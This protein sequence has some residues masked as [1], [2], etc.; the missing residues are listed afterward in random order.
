[1]PRGSRPRSRI[2]AIYGAFRPS[3]SGIADELGI[4]C[5]TESRTNSASAA[6]LRRLARALYSPMGGLTEG[7]LWDGS[8]PNR[9][10]FP[11]ARVRGTHADHLRALP[12]AQ[13]PCAW[14]GA[15]VRTSTVAVDGKPRTV[16]LPDLFEFPS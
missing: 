16:P 5:W 15:I 4:R 10:E 6:G 13:G 1:M 3:G 9:P 8:R 12:R 7:R 2:P 11:P 14:G